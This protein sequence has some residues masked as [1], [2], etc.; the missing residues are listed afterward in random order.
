V[1]HLDDARQSIADTDYSEAIIELKHALNKDVQLVEARVLLGHAYF[2]I[3]DFD[4][5]VK[6]LYRALDSGEEIDRN[7]AV[8]ILA[9][10]LLHVGDYDRLDGLDISGLAS[11]ERSTTLAAKGLAVLYKG[12]QLAASDIIRT[13]VEGADAS[14]YARV[15]GA[16]LAMAN[17]DLDAAR[18]RLNKITAKHP[19]YAPAWNLIGDIEAA[20][21][22]PKEAEKAYTRV[23]NI[24]SK[25]FDAR[26]NRTMMR[27][28]QQD[29][30]GARDDL[31]RLGAAHNRAAEVHPGVSFADGILLMQS[32]RYDKARKAF[33]KTSD[34][35]YLYPLSYYFMAVIDLE[36]GTNQRA[37][38]EVYRFIAL[39]PESIEGPK[40]AARLE[41]DQEGYAA[42]ENLLAPVLESYPDD[43]E[44]LN[45][46]ASAKLEL[47]KGGEA[48]DLL[49][50]VIELD[51]KSPR[52][53][54]R[55]GAGHLALGDISAG[56]EVLQD[57]V[58]SNP[59]FEQADILI[60]LNYLRQNKLKKAVAAARDYHSR[61]PGSAT[62]YN[63]LGRALFANGDDDEAELFFRGAMQLSPEDPAARMGLAA[64]ALRQERYQ[65]ARTFYR[66]ILKYNSND[67]QTQM[68]IASSYALQGREDDL[69]RSLQL[70]ADA[71]PEAIEPLL[72]MARF[73]IGRG[74]LD[75]AGPLLARLSNLQRQ[76]EPEVLATLASFQLAAGRY[77]QALLTLEKL[78]SIRSS[79]SHYHY[80]KS[81]A[82]AGLG[83]E[84]NALL[85]LRNAADLDPGHFYTKIALARLALWPINHSVLMRSCRILQILRRRTRML[86]SLGWRLL[87]L[88]DRRGVLL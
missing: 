56:I 58:R 50:K 54:V 70:T 42:A 47:G 77:N 5:A 64:I 84:E 11:K 39:A 35:S 8:P 73:L 62:S 28:Y 1:E 38:G 31:K 2:E 79:V 52:A 80:M 87:K 20:Q 13:A 25:S 66:K 10:T 65:H 74:R 72:V 44:S 33:E 4:G 86:C 43:I 57:S 53:K 83:D 85:S 34:F 37:L 7:F 18:K 68:K 59:K 30:K 51:P 88:L 14:L 27:I 46:M 21:R 69:F 32:K 55:L 23:L 67:L 3:G 29:Y 26:L 75:E 78:T 36:S 49:E 40:L 12:D 17:G 63:L 41:L 61:N 6:E 22:N 45:L 71:H 24:S 48:L 81:K 19:K 16:R 82:Y 76:D 15:A 60:V 9:K